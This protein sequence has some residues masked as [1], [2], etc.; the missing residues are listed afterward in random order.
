MFDSVVFRLVGAGVRR[1][2]SKQLVA[3]RE[4]WLLSQSH[5]ELAAGR[6]SGV[7]CGGRRAGVNALTGSVL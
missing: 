4:R 7:C 6:G 1:M 3:C 5:R 2:S